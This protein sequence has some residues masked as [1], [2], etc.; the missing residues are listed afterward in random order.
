MD[1]TKFAGRCGDVVD[2]S[3]DCRCALCNKDT[4]CKILIKV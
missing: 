4:C 2:L 3:P 1:S